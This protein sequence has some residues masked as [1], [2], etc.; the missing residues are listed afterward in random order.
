M[1][2]KEFLEKLENHQYINESIEFIIG[3][4]IHN[5]DIDVKPLIDS[6][7]AK[8]EKMRKEYELDLEKALRIVHFKNSSVMENEEKEFVDKYE[9]KF[10]YNE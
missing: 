7:F 8:V 4:F 10:G 1:T 2:G 6:Y 9:R 3:E 5:G